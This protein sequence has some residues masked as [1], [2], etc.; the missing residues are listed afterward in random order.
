V[1][2]ELATLLALAARKLF[3][4]VSLPESLPPLALPRN[5]PSAART[6]CRKQYHPR[7]WPRTLSSTW[8]LR[9]AALGLRI[10]EYCCAS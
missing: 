5:Q 1:L 9:A 4:P 10:K 2:P 8:R 3:R 7:H 6:R